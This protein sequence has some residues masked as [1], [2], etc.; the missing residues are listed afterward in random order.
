MHFIYIISIIFTP[1][2]HVQYICFT[3]G[4]TKVQKIK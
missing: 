1:S 4:E 2:K 3:K